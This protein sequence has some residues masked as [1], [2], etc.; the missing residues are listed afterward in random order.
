MTAVAIKTPYTR[1]EVLKVFKGIGDYQQWCGYCVHMAGR[2]LG[3]AFVR[4]AA[5]ECSPEE[6]QRRR[7]ELA[8]ALA[9]SDRAAALA[10]L[11]RELPEF[12]ALVPD[13]HRSVFAYAVAEDLHRGERDAGLGWHAR[14]LAKRSRNQKRAKRRRKI[15]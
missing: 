9:D 2:V 11:E 10:F 7:D 15:H 6:A 8:I 1:A 3:Y 5:S 4:M 14:A 12:I 13:E